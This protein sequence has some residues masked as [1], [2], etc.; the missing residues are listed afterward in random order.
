MTNQRFVPPALVLALGLGAWACGGDSFGVQEDCQARGNTS[1]AD[2]TPP[3][4]AFVAPEPGAT[5]G[6]A[7]ELTA[8]AT[9]NCEISAVRFSI[10]A[11]D[12]LGTASPAP[13]ASTYTL[14]W[15]TRSL[16]NGPVTLALY[17]DDGH[18]DLEG[19]PTPNTG[20]QT[21]DFIIMN[22]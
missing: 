22:P 8:T 12:P 7:V 19:H 18:R 4:V 9:D 13:A 15:D 3:S 14:L 20:F 5:L 11:G 21:R 6:G 17:A 1:G 16:A 10:Y 2:R